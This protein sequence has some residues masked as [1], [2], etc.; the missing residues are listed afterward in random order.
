[1]A[2]AVTAS[3]QAAVDA[4]RGILRRGG[5]AVDAAVAASLKARFADVH[6][7]DR[8][9]YFAPLTAIGVGPEGDVTV[10]LDDRLAPGFGAVAIGTPGTAAPSPVRRPGTD[11][12]PERA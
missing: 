8:R 4:G 1:M 11:Y 5:N 9:R 2:A 7:Q 12:Q 3:S 6:D 10:G